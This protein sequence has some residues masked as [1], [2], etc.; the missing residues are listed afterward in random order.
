MASSI[1][2]IDVHI[3]DLIVAKGGDLFKI[4]SFSTRNVTLRPIGRNEVPFKMSKKEV[5]SNIAST[6]WRIAKNK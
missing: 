4:I 2:N 5:R 1:I 3:G 6:N